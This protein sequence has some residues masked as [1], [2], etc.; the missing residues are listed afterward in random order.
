LPADR[1]S[2]GPFPQAFPTDTEGDGFPYFSN[3]ARKHP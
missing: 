1:V 2:L 3:W